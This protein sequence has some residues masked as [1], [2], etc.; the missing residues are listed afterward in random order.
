MA[1]SSPLFEKFLEEFCDSYRPARGHW[2][3][4]YEDASYGIEIP[5][6]KRG[7]SNF[8]SVFITDAAFIAGEVPYVALIVAPKSALAYTKNPIAGIKSHSVLTIE[9]LPKLLGIN[10]FKDEYFGPVHGCRWV[11]DKFI[12]WRLTN[13]H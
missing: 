13:G 10:L 12:Q 1:S 8:A 7:Y 3:I 5:S 6:D 4:A 11:I 9:D 2:N